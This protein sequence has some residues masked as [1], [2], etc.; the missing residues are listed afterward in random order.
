M[1]E[2]NVPI[3]PLVSV[4]IPTYNRAQKLQRAVDALFSS[5]YKNLEII[6]SDN[7][8][9]DDT[10]NV[11][12]TLEKLDSRIKYYRHPENRGPTTNFEFARSRATG[13]YFLWHGDDD[14]LDPEYI[15]ICVTELEK[16]SSLVLASGLAA[17]I[18]GNGMIVR[19]GKFF[20]VLERTP[21]R[22]T[23]KYLMQVTE[24]SIFCGAY[25]RIDTLDCCM[26]DCLSG[27]WIWMCEVLTKGK[28]KM[29]KKTNVYREYE[30]ST[31]SSY[32]NIARTIGAPIWNLYFPEIAM[33][34][35]VSAI[36]TAW[37]LNKKII[38]K[39][40]LSILKAMIFLLVSTRAIISTWRLFIIRTIKSFKINY[41]LNFKDK[42][43]KK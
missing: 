36:F 32:K 24:N 40:S 30:E 2:L 20:S 19:Y 9:S 33:G 5:T 37:I 35:N 34:R 12:L 7:A 6:I 27:D 11:C 31:S 23:L 1:S 10:E 22:R 38:K 29:L 16:D 18:K 3:E 21:I 8:S 43:K 4:C 13:K 28:A 15:N 42:N 41:S 39:F 26:P 25:R 14:Y 17:Y